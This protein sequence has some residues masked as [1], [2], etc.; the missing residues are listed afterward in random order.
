MLDVGC[1]EGQ[2]ALYLAGRGYPQVEAFDL[3]E[4]AVDKARRLARQR[5]A[6]L[7]LWPQDLRT[8]SFARSYGVILSFGTLH[9]VSREQWR[10]FLLRAQ[11][12]TLPGGLNIIQLFTD[13]VPASPDIAPFAVGLAREG[14]LLGLYREWEVLHFSAYTFE[15]EH[16]GVPRHVHASNKIVARRRGQGGTNE[17]R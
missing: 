4:R 2:N 15:D 14:E 9:F 16:P 3:S 12:H 5:R 1:G 10:A 13:R 17:D 8:F 6:A 7:K 11:A